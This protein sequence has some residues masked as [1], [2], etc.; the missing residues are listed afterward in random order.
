MLN[1]LQLQK[2]EEHAENVYEAIVVIAKRAR[3]I[4]EEVRKATIAA[5]VEE[6]DSFDVFSDEPNF[7]N[8]DLSKKDEPKP[9]TLALEEFLAGKIKFEYGKI[10]K[11]N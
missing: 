2:L 8:V 7:D 1:T 4:N 3:Q 10:E 9:T 5:Y 6:D 11:L